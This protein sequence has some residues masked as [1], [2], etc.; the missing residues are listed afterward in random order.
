MISSLFEIHA[1]RGPIFVDFESRL[2]ER[3]RAA[4]AIEANG[5]NWW[6]SGW[7]R[8]EQSPAR[9]NRIW[10]LGRESALQGGGR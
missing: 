8:C 1:G 10:V 6:L 4:K 7:F 5:L 9:S 2:G 3:K